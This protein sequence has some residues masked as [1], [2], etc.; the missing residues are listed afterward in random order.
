[1]STKAE[2]TAEK[3]TLKLET[4]DG[5]VLKLLRQMIATT[6][7]TADQD[8]EQEVFLNVLEAFRHRSDIRHPRALMRKI[9]RDTV[10]NAWRSRLKTPSGESD[11]TLELRASVAPRMEEDIDQQR[12]VHC[13]HESIFELGCDI[14][15]PVYLFYVEHYPINDIIRVFGKSR[16]AVKMAL[17]RGRHQ[18]SRMLR[19]SGGSL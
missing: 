6:N 18:L 14:R 16:P 11:D 4:G 19:T 17:H 12:R 13:L 9:T 15:G 5:E 7:G 2:E 1:M 8:L 3:V 10:V